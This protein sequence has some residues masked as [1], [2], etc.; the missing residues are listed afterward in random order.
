VRPAAAACDLL[1]ERVVESSRSRIAIGGLAG[2][3]ECCR[4]ILDLRVDVPIVEAAAGLRLLGN[5]RSLFRGSEYPIGIAIFD[6]G[7][8]VTLIE[9]QVV[10]DLGD[11][12]RLVARVVSTVTI[13][14]VLD[15]VAESGQRDGLALRIGVRHRMTDEQ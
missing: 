5:E 11:L 1:R 13:L 2:L 6:P 8:V 7:A 9:Q 15:A 3:S 14:P 12:L 10:G 4:E